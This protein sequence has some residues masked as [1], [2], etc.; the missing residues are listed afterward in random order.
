MKKHPKI[1]VYFVS[2]KWQKPLFRVFARGC[3][4][5]FGVHWPLEKCKNRRTGRR[6]LRIDKQRANRFFSPY[7]LP[8][9]SIIPEIGVFFS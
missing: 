3:M 7:R 5:A 9:V 4:R 1:G 2:K 6:F 8:T